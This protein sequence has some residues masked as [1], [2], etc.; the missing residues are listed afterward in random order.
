MSIH[1]ANAPCS[2]GVDD[3]KNPFLPPF[4]KCSPKQQQLAIKVLN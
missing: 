2:W 4:K 1:I 3:P